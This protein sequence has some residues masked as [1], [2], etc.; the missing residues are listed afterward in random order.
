MA[1]FWTSSVLYHRL[2]LYLGYELLLCKILYQ[3]INKQD[4]V[5]VVIFAGGKFRENVGKKFH[6]GVIF[7]KL[8]LFP[9]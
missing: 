6:A 4:T 7:T 8:L 3:Y 9:S 1:S 2:Y 5:N